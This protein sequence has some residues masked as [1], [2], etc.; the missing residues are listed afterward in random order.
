MGKMLSEEQANKVYDILVRECRA[1]E[2]TRSGF[3]M[4]QTTEVM[5]EW[6]FCGVFGFG[7]KFHNRDDRWFVSMYPESQTPYLLT[8]QEK[9]NK[10]LE[11]LKG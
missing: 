5:S 1:N 10:L 11:E 6:R 2:L 3:V 7:G 8:I 4:N 9:V